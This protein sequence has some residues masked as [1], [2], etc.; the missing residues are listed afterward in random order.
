[1]RIS[2][3]LSI[4]LLSTIFLGCSNIQGKQEKNAIGEKSK[5]EANKSI[6]PEHLTYETFLKKVWNFEKHPKEWVYEG[7]EPCVI[8]FYADWCGP[9]KRVAPIMEEM[10]NKYKG[11]VKIYKINVDKEQKLAAVFQIRSIPAVLFSPMKGKPMM[12]VGLLPKNSYIKIIN[13]QLLHVKEK[14]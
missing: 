6:A 9:C 10:A 1:M 13:T 11:K 12:Q 7:T 2:R 4:F 5:T 14:K 8:D 3:F